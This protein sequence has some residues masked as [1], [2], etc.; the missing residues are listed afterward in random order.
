VAQTH[1][2]LELVKRL[3]EEGHGVVIISHN[4]A[5]VFEVADRITV[6]RLGRFVGTY[7]AARVGHEQLVGL[8]TGA[9]PGVPDDADE[10]P[11]AVPGT[12]GAAPMPTEPM[13]NEPLPA[14]PPP[15]TDP[16]TP[17]VPEETGR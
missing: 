4:L 14:E 13:P 9:V 2:V 10:D 3:R 8:M 6:L 15:P 7:D 5:D 11:T 16:P 12:A 1:E 17:D